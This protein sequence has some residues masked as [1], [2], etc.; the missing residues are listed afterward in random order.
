[1]RYYISDLHF[2]HDKVIRLDKRSFESLEEM[3]EQMVLRWNRRVKKND[4]V[5]ILGDFIGGD[6]REANRIL[7][8]LNGRLYLILGNH[9]EVVYKKGFNKERF[10]WIKAYEELFDNNRR[11][12]LCHYP[13]LCYRGQYQLTDKGKPRSFMLHGHVHNSQDEELL[14]SFQRLTRETVIADAAGN[15]RNIPCNLINC[16]CKFSD[17]VPLTLDEWILLTNKRVWGE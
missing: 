16:F 4:Q 8:R 7:E 13:I 14:Q 2:F 5:V 6:V 17:Y 15:I 11:V 9:D 12:I 10:V 3:N 1:M